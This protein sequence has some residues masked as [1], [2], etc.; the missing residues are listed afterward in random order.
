MKLPRFP[1]EGPPLPP[2]KISDYCYNLAFFISMAY[3]EAV[4]LLY[5]L[6]MEREEDAKL[7][8]ATLYDIMPQIRGLRFVEESERLEMVKRL[9]EIDSALRQGD[10]V[11]A[12]FN[13]DQLV[14]GLRGA[15]LDVVVRCEKGRW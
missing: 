12:H 4:K 7:R 3:E 13:A 2:R 14:A 8:L 11:S 9:G 1:W 10:L 15:L 6:T 5:D